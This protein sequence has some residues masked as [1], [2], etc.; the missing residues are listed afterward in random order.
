[1][2]LVRRWVEMP[3][4]RPGPGGHP[5]TFAY[6]FREL[7][8]LTGLS[9]AAIRQHVAR[10]TLIPGDLGTVLRFV[11]RVAP[12]VLTGEPAPAKRPRAPRKDRQLKR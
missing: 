10:G 12:W 7:S 9:E 5:R 4:G 8:L 11:A 1:M 3:R 6:G 2:P